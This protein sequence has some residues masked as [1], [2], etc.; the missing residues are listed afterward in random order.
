MLRTTVLATLLGAFA[1]ALLMHPAGADAKR[2][3]SLGF[4]EPRFSSENE[5]TRDK[6]FDRAE[7]SGG[8]IARVGI[9]WR[10][11]APNE[12]ADPSDPDSAGYF[13]A[14]PDSAVREADKRG[15]DVIFTIG[16]APN[17]A[18]GANRPASVLGG[19]WKPDPNKLATFGKALAKRY[20][21]NTPD[22]LNPGQKLPKVNKYEVWNESNLSAFLT[23]QTENGQNFAVEHYR[24]MVNAFYPAVHAIQSDAQVIAGS[25]SPIGSDTSGGAG[26]RQGPLKF[27]REL[28]CVKGKKKVKP[29]N[30]GE[31]ISF[32]VLSHHPINVDRPPLAKAKGDDAGIAETPLIKNMLKV[33]EKAGTVATP[34]KHPL[35]MT[36]IWWN[37][38]PPKKGNKIPTL[39]EQAAY[40]EESFYYLWTQ[41]IPVAMLYQVGDEKGSVFQTGV[42][43]DSG[44]P[45]PSQTAFS[46]P[47]VG[48][49]K[50]KTKVGVWGIAPASGKVQIQVKGKGGSTTKKLKAKKG[51]V[52]QTTVKLKGKGKISAKLGKDKSLTWDQSA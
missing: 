13:W 6:W 22:P 38:N 29:F 2:G 26:E 50:S 34:G 44:K 47:L 36:E 15:M 27:L 40:I 42:Y 49:R 25:L 18:E 32:D 24:K 12:P 14:G 20:N 19:T 16:V 8:K 39:D 30:C 3:I 46:F 5:K 48:D 43:F 28:L 41:K 4:A 10:G 1:V 23:P 51:G 7:E 45:K 21:G 37:S 52:F 9:G 35:W 11:I 31:K 33:S 17:W